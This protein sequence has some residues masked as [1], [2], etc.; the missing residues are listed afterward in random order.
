MH[1]RRNL[2]HSAIA[3]L[4]ILFRPWLLTGTN[5]KTSPV[6]SRSPEASSCTV[7]LT[8]TVRSFL[9]FVEAAL[10]VTRS[11]P[12]SSQRRALSSESLHPVVAII[13]KNSR[14]SCCTSFLGCW[15]QL[16]I[17]LTSSSVQATLCALTAFTG[18]FG[19]GHQ[20]ET[21]GQRKSSKRTPP[22]WAEA[23]ETRY[24]RAGS[25]NI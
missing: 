7:L 11:G 22:S 9:L 5:G 15:M 2:L 21:P 19:T 24:F 18:V 17:L 3:R 14:H 6:A 25:I 10:K 1:G 16:N 4:S 23:P 12:K 13:V 8:G 20:G